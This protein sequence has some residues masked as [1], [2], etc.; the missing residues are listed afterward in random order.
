LKYFPNYLIGLLGVGLAELLRLPIPWMLGPLFL[1]LIASQKFPLKSLPTSSTKY[2]VM[3]IGIYIGSRFDPNSFSRDFGVLVFLL[4]ISSF[5]G[6]FLSFYL[7]KNLGMSKQEAAG[8]ALPGAFAFLLLYAGEH[9]IPL[10]RILI[11]HLMRIITILFF[12]PIF[13]GGVL[14]QEIL[15][16]KAIFTTAAFFEWTILLLFVGAAAFIADKFIPIQSSGFLAASILSALLYA[17]DIIQNQPPAW[18]LNLLLFMIAVTIASRLADFQITKIFKDIFLGLFITFVLLVICVGTAGIYS[19]FYEVSFLT[20]LLALIPGG[21]HEISLI[22]L[23]YDLDPVL[24]A[25]IHWLRVVM[26][27]AAMPY[28]MLWAGRTQNQ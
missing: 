9:K 12:A 6:F 4:V 11:I 19:F 20:Y 25:F 26:I 28:V 8:S 23:V 2:F 10:N 5:L 15:S 14:E 21:I 17:L 13:F 16:T 24:I 18:G 3:L 22:A 7:L 27:T 1:I